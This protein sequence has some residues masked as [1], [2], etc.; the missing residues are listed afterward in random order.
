[1][2]RKDLERIAL[3]VSSTGSRVRTA[4]KIEFI[5][6]QGPI[7]RDVRVQG[8]EWS[9]DSLRDL[10]KILWAAQRA[11][12]YALAAYR[13]F[14]KMPSSQFSPDGL[15]GGRGY[16]QSVK[17][18]RNSLSSIVEGLSAFTDTVHDEVNADH[19]ASE[20][21][22]EAS[23]LVD[24]ADSVKRNP[25][26]FVEG[27]FREDA[28]GEDGFNEPIQ[29]PDP[30]DYNPS[31]ED[32]NSDVS[33]DEEDSGQH[34]TASFSDSPFSIL[35]PV[36]GKLEKTLPGS[37]LP[38][39]TGE[40]G[41]AK[42]A[43]EIV[44]NTT[45]P[46]SGN[47][48]ASINRILMR[49]SRRASS[50][51]SESIPSGTTPRPVMDKYGPAEGNEAGHF[52]HEEVWPSDD[53]TGEGLWSGVNDSKPLLEDWCADGVT[54]YDN[55]TD[56]DSSILAI[57]SRVSATYSWL[58]GTTNNKNL[59]FY[60]RGLT[61]ED[62]DWMRENSSPDLPAN[63]TSSKPKPITSDLWMDK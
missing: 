7:R 15:L 20:E 34:Q 5:R 29:N 35:K 1:M 37:Q 53:P 4:G 36:P 26:A 9:S 48:A 14:S 59:D 6:D 2:K 44:M 24:G 46:K 16:I 12:S 40:Q 25:E 18:M 11:H 42:T 62:I 61:E 8:F 17:D 27:E 21:S 39:G 28:S 3:N 13:L 56:G 50:Y 47:Y 33:E 49:H 31:F 54:G 22:E 23:D 60:A 45:T 58:P 19:W 38:A 32:P 55:A 52:N 41:Q 10:A 30:E 63:L 57:S 51:A 43:P